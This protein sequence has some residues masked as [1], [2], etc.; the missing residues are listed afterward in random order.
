MTDDFFHSLEQVFK[1]LPDRS[2]REDALRILAKELAEEATFRCLNCTSE[3]EARPQQH[4]RR[5]FDD[6]VI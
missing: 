5:P 1:V 4:S 3:Q 2:D 6:L